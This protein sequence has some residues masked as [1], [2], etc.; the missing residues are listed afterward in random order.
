[1]AGYEKVRAIYSL[2]DLFV[3]FV[4]HVKGVFL[5]NTVY[6][7][8]FWEL[9]CKSIFVNSYFLDIISTPN[10]NPGLGN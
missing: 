5:I 7:Y 4:L 2:I 10:L 1:M 8:F 3:G 9:H 6:D